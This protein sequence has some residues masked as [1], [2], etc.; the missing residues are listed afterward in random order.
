VLNAAGDH[1]AGTVTV[2]VV[3]MDGEMGSPNAGR[4]MTEWME[5]GSKKVV[6]HD[7]D[8]KWP[9]RRTKKAQWRRNPRKGAWWRWW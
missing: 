4:F 8:S 7:R 5:A 1:D 9:G 3:A 6:P 2:V